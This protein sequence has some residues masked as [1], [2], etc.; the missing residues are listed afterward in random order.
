MISHCI[1]ADHHSDIRSSRD[2]RALAAIAVP[3]GPRSHSGIGSL[4]AIAGVGPLTKPAGREAAESAEHI[5]PADEPQTPGHSSP[6]L[7]SI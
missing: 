2:H 4:L 7:G 5:V 1:F 6:D 3:G